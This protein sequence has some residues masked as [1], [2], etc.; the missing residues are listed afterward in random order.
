MGEST[1]NA[2]PR[3]MIARTIKRFSYHD[4]KLEPF[5]IGIEL[6]LTIILAADIT[7]QRTINKQNKLL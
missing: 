5:S 2:R 1:L 7:E 4:L 3:S 6:M